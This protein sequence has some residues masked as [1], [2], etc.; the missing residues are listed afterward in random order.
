MLSQ[1]GRI[2]PSSFGFNLIGAP[3]TNYIVQV[4]TN[5]SSTNWATLV[6]TNL[7]GNSVFIQD[8]QATNGQ[9]FYRALRGL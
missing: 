8:N 5:L 6:T 1:P 4:S 2:G 7:P 3:G 9:R